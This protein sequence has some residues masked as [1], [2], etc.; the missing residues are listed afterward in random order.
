MLSATVQDARRTLRRRANPRKAV[1]LQR[2]FKTGKGEYAEGDRFLGVTVPHVR[3]VARQ[4]RELPL[5][6]VLGLLHSLM[7]EERLLALVILVR[8]FQR[9]D[10][11]TRQKMFTAYLRNRRHIN[12][13]D[14]VDTSAEHILGPMLLTGNRRVLDQLVASQ[15]LWDRR[16]AVMSTF[17]FIRHG[18]FAE[19]L[20]L[21][22]R[23]LTDEHDLMHKAVGWMLREIGKRDRPTLE[24]FLCRHAR[25]MPRTM[26]RYAIEHFPGAKRRRYLAGKV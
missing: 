4:F 16:I 22:K 10:A 17:H 15:R 2:F 5:V 26:L 24:R 23:L 8:Q 18:R 25:K 13:W 14:L 3:A 20:R 1:V 11:R 19:T 12:N 7:H 9:G 6:D 21:A